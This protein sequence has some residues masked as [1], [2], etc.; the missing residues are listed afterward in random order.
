M[1]GQVSHL[2]YAQQPPQSQGKE[3][4]FT[5]KELRDAGLVIRA[6]GRSRGYY[7]SAASQ[8]GTVPGGHL[9]SGYSFAIRTFRRK[10]TFLTTRTVRFCA[11]KETYESSGF[12]GMLGGFMKSAV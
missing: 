6:K 9:M 7:S 5:V 4:T 10:R 11:L 2:E 1:G 12:I 3:G 8:E